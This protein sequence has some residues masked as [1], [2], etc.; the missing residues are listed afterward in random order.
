MED[1]FRVDLF[2]SNRIDIQLL[3]RRTL[4]LQKIFQL[5]IFCFDVCGLSDFTFDDITKIK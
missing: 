1:H 2:P 4:V 3:L 5:K